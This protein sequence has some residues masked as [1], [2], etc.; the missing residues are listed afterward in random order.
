MLL[1]VTSLAAGTTAWAQP[2]ANP[3]DAE[4]EEGNAAVENAA[5]RVGEL[6]SRLAEVSARRDEL[7]AQVE[8]AMEDANRA[9]VDLEAAEAAAQL[10][11]D[12]ARTAQIEA[13]ASADHIE[14]VRAQIDDFA[15]ASH[16]QGTVVGSLSAYFGAE[17]PDDL[18]ERVQLLDAISGSHL[19]LLDE[20]ERAR[21]DK[22]NKDSTARAALAEA[23]S[24]AAAAQEAKSDADEAF[25]AAV[26]AEQ[27]QQADITAVEDERAAVEAELVSAR[28]DVG[29]LEEQRTRYEE[30]EREQEAAAEAAAASVVAA[31]AAQPPG[32]P[33]GPPPASG[34]SASNAIETVIARA[35]AQLGVPYSWGGGNAHGPTQGVRDGGVADAHGDYQKV[36]FD[37]SGLMVYAFAGAGVSLPKYS[38]YQYQSGQ[39]VPLAQMRRGDMIFWQTGGRI[40]HVALYLGDGMMVEAPYSGNQVRVTP[41][42]YGGIAPYAVRM[43]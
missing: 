35:V 5:T 21:T 19:D 1:I 18:L 16:Q 22:V 29:G 2:P 11:A 27:A 15:A 33:A 24:G 42:R 26:A 13:D 8:L 37:C 25:A 39:R 32:Q 36:G 41:V 17:S 12:V 43:L 31:P 7:L 40:H 14:R 6:T 10:A 28:A 30:W 20:L 23:E 34:A 9:M 38:G 4:I 3:D